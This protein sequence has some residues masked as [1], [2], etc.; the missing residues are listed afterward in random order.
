MT[1]RSGISK[2]QRKSAQV[3][4]IRWEL[5]DVLNEDFS[6]EEKQCSAYR[7]LIESVRIAYIYSVP[8]LE[9]EE[10][11]KTSS[12][13]TV[14]VISLAGSGGAVLLKIVECVFTWLSASP[15]GGTP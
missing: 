15:A 12:W 4:K 11:Q 10:Q 6:E 9:Q 7:E 8:K 13:K 3:N 2:W 14:L 5:K 1:K